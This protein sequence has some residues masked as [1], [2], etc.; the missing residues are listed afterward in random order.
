M[1]YSL[2]PT[3]LEAI[4]VAASYDNDSRFNRPLE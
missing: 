4:E 1:F 2:Q 3:F